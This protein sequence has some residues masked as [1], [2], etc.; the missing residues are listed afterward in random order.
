[1][2]KTFSVNLGGLVYNIDE[3]AYIQ[4]TDYLQD[5][6]RHLGNDAS[7]EEVLNDIEQRI[8]ELFT[9]WMQG[10]REV[11]TSA[12]VTRI[13]DILGRP[14]QFDTEEGNES[15]KTSAGDNTSGEEKSQSSKKTEYHDGPRRRLYRDTDNAV[16]GGVCSGIAAYLNVGVVLLRVIVFVMIWFGGSGLLIY[17]L[18]WIIIPEA[19]TAAQKLEMKG[20]DVTL[21]NIEKKVKEEFF[22][23]KD[24]FGNY[25]ETNDVKDKTRNFGQRLGDFILI[26]I[27]VLLGFIAGIIG[28]SGLLTLIALIFALIVLWTGGPL[29]FGNWIDLPFVYDYSMQSTAS[30]LTLGIILA[31]GIPFIAIFNLLFGRLLNLKPTP[32]WLNWTAL[33]LWFVGLALVIVPGLHFIGNYGFNWWV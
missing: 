13:I 28:I 16:L 20:E 1:M 6:K 23:A 19:R 33:I 10:K 30:L 3:D 31:I 12:D 22:R 4:L 32:K 24:R 5:V 7:S 27:K 25:V 17:I 11:V 21:D 14:E 15:E 29:F 18:C 9:E 2:K 8:S 26:C